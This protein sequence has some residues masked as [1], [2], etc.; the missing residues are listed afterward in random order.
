M[1]ISFAFITLVA[2]TQ[3][4]LVV[5]PSLPSRNVKELMKVA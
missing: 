1:S 4:L 5:H 2:K 3:N